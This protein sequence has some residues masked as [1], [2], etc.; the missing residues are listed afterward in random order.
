MDEYTPEQIEE[1]KKDPEKLVEALNSTT[2][3]L[4]TTSAEK[5]DLAT[6]LAKSEE[7]RKFQG[8]NFKKFRD[9]TEAEKELLTEKEKEIA[10]RQDLL[11]EE[12]E[13]DKKERLE[14]ENKQ[15]TN[16]KGR[17]FRD[18]ARGDEKLIEKI[19]YHYNRLADA[20]DAKDE[21]AIEKLAIDAFNLLG[22]ERPDPIRRAI[23]SRGSAGDP[24]K[25]D[26]SFA[27]TD[28]GKALG[29]ML[30]LNTPAAK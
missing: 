17:I 1:M 24:K 7:D 9:M 10:Q 18:L 29:G 21:E 16:I 11:E 8:Q 5:T 19:E 23:S 20:K 26:K 15:I 13:K 27:E 3:K 6:K 14:W 4:K 2:E 12:R 30:G 28:E 22:S 25:G